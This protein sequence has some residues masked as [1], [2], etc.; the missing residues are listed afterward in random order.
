MKILKCFH[1]LKG[2]LCQ[3]LIANELVTFHLRKELHVFPLD[4]G[5]TLGPMLF[6]ECQDCS[7][8]QSVCMFLGFS[9]NAVLES[10]D[11]VLFSIL[12]NVKYLPW[13]IFLI[14]SEFY[15]KNLFVLVQKPT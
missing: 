5:R 6:S 7:V 13:L 11:P 12:R 1:S 14:G 10:Q 8:T 9:G 4:V 3:E 2:E 15:L